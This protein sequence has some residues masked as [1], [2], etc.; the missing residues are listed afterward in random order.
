[1]TS[2]ACSSTM[3]LL[4]LCTQAR[5]VASQTGIR[6]ECLGNVMR[7]SLDRSVLAGRRTEIDV[8][9]GTRTFPLTHVLASQCGYTVRPDPWGNIQIYVSLQ[10]CYAEQEEQKI[11]HLGL[12]L[13]MYE[14]HLPQTIKTVTKSCSYDTWASREILCVSLRFNLPHVE[15]SK[16][17]IAGGKTDG[18]DGLIAVPMALRSLLSLWKIV[19]YTPTERPI[20]PEELLGLG[21]GFQASPTQLIIRSP[22]NTA[23]AY[24]QDVAGVPMQVFKSSLFYKHLWMMTVVDAAAACP[25]GG[26]VFTETLITWRVP[27]HIFLLLSSHTSEMIELHMGINGRR[28]D[29]Y[30]MLAKNYTMSVT[31]A[32]IV[33]TIPV[34]SPDGC[35]KSYTF[36]DTYYVEYSIE[37]MLEILW[38][39]S[40]H[41]HET[42]YKVIFPIT[43]PQ[44]ANPP[45]LN[46]YTVPENRVFTVQLST[47][48]HDVEL[49]NITF[50]NALLTVAEANERGFNVQEQWF[51][52]GSKA[53]N[54]QVPFSDSAVL[55]SNP[56]LESTTYSLSLVYGFL[57]FP[58]L[59]T[60][61]HKESVTATLK[62]IVLPKVNGTCQQNSFNIIIKYGNQGH[63]F[64]TWV[65]KSPL[66][67]EQFSFHENG[68]H[69][70]IMVP[71]DAP[72]V[73]FEAIKPAAIKARLD[74][75]LRDPINNWNISVFS[76]AC[77]FP[78]TMAEC[79]PNGTMG[80]LAVKLESVPSL[81]P[82]QLTLTDPSCKPLFSTSQFAYF[83]FSVN[84]CGTT[85][86]F[87]DGV[88]MYAN[89]VSLKTGAHLRTEEPEYLL[90]LS[91]TYTVKSNGTLG[92][93]TTGLT[94]RFPVP[95][96]G[97]HQCN[98][99]QMDTPIAEFNSGEL[100]VR[101]KLFQ[102]KTYSRFFLKESFPLQVF[103]KQPLYFE[104]ELM[105]STDPRVELILDNCWATMNEAREA[106]ARWDIIVNSCENL[107][108]LDHTV[109]HPV[110]ADHRVQFPGHYKRFEVR[111]FSF[112]ED[113]VL[114]AQ[115]FFHCDV[116][117][118]NSNGLLDEVCNGQC[119][120]RQRMQ[121][122]G[123]NRAGEGNR[124]ERSSF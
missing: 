110:V 43:T 33:I 50:Q 15:L 10:N 2:S 17:K 55:R 120:K 41:P 74:L 94:T 100:P 13:R 123:L 81:S 73:A 119:S 62:D 6:T 48:L 30:E 70:A 96:S 63:N 86:R 49:V 80:V 38:R 37:P 71:F 101:M 35:H 66:T 115:V 118:C 93:F 105:E 42:K 29:Q 122:E 72:S 56:S 91:C 46:D 83:S 18:D 85:R 36:N 60:F 44:F 116:L 108:D 9:N 75:I 90:T 107:E 106:M 97:L 58:E 3:W 24:P 92:F 8:I 47:F 11:F 117:L 61:S 57:I 64:L 4:V 76:L 79:F 51:S 59:A 20:L 77:N 21:Y 121:Q 98:E 23:E 87:L 39:E 25:T 45:R 22:Y 52:N 19:F 89:E 104:V 84:S 114:R 109:F 7:V 102:D 32:H 5:M 78:L 124:V 26:A 54:L 28:L 113:Q 88:M 65:G 68:T 31:E 111:M 69:F 112:I 27:R 95:P 1:M 82:S 40:P 12:Q 67:A 16:H 34:G 103:L 14:G 99:F 53:F